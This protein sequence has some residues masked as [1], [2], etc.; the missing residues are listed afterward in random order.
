MLNSEIAGDLVERVARDSRGKLLAYLASRSRDLDAAEDALADAFRMAL[1]T[2]PRTGAPDKPEAWL[3]T[4]ARRKLIDEARRGKARAAAERDLVSLAREA[5][6]IAETRDIF[7]DE[8]LK[9]LFACAH[10]AIAEN[11]RTP[12]VLQVVLGLDAA[13]IASAFLVQPAAMGQRLARA[14]TKIREAG[15]RLDIPESEE[16]PERLQVVLEAIYAAYIGAW[17]DISGA[18]PRRRGLAAESVELAGLTAS[19]LPNE[20]E[21]KGLLALMLFCEARREAR[22]SASGAYVPLLEQDV[23][24]WNASLLREAEGVLAEASRLQKIGRFQLEAAIQSAHSERARTGQVDWD[25]IALFYE[26]LARI[27]PTV[28]ALVGR[29][30]AAAEARGPELGLALLEELPIA[31]VKTYQPYWATRAHLLMFLDRKDESREAFQKAIGLCDDD[32]MRE[33]LIKKSGTLRASGEPAI[34]STVADP[35]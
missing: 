5:Q 31:R 9:L 23:A 14:K 2:W 30:A 17:E 12:L 33:F 8:R 22:R 18:D 11:T 13:R 15:I 16:L 1:E 3:L 32:A 10:P 35:G 27:A 26:G 21:A 28:G 20:A 25:A 34:R 4:V 24:L 6:A 7:P 19:L 29:A